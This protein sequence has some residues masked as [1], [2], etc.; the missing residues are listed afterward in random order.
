MPLTIITAI[1]LTIITAITLIVMLGC[2]LALLFASSRCRQI[3]LA[4][5]ICAVG[6]VL[7]VLHWV[8]AVVERAP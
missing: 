7:A 2:K 6:V 8:V 4:L 5:W 1:T 3:D